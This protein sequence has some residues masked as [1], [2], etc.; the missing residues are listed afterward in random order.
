MS[1]NKPE[2]AAAQFRQAVKSK[3]DSQPARNALG[4]ALQASGHPDEAEGEFNRSLQLNPR[5]A[6]TLERLGELYSSERRYNAAIEKFQQAA[7]ISPADPD[8]Q[9][10]WAVA[11]SNNGDSARAIQMLSRLIEAQPNLPQAHFN[12]ATV[13][14]NAKQFREA[15][16]EYTATLKLDPENDVA[17]LSLVKAYASISNFDSALPVASEY[18]KRKPKDAEGHYL[19]GNVYRGMGDYPSAERELRFA[20]AGE[21]EYGPHYDL[22]FVLLK[23]GKAKEALPQLQRAIKI[24]P[25]SAEAHF[26]LAS[27]LRALNMPAEAGKELDEFR[28]QKQQSVD[29]NIAAAAGNEANQLLSRGDYKAAAESYRKALDLDPKNAKTGSMFPLRSENCAN[30]WNSGLRSKRRLSSTQL[31]LLLITSLV[32]LMRPT[33]IKLAPK[34][35]LRKRWI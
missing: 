18:V 4:L 27:V 21:D 5:S 22:G 31:S 11:Y 12:L 19:L 32:C 15:A 24:R 26:Q 20:V 9:I 28:Q 8:L 1:D 3:P 2:Q 35:G 10:E 6:D 7:E 16:D 30:I 29:E 13:Y 33:V 17:R 25:D 34:S 14:A 23:E